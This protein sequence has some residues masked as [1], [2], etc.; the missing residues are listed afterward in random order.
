MSKQKLVHTY[1][2]SIGGRTR[3]AKGLKPPE[4]NLSPPEAL[5]H[6]ILRYTLI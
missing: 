6:K 5:A 3:V 1:N 4:I 2:Q